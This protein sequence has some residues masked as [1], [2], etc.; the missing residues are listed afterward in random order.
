MCADLEVIDDNVVE[1][2]EE[3]LTLSLSANEQSVTMIVPYSA[4]TVTI[5]ENNND[6]SFYGDD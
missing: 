1:L 4:T 6:G 2:N 3:F 5:R